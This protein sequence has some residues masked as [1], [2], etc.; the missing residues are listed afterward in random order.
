MN[1]NITYIIFLILFS[2]RIFIS[3]S[4]KESSDY[5]KDFAISLQ[6]VILNKYRDYNET[7]FDSNDFKKCNESLSFNISNSVNGIQLKKLMGIVGNSGKHFNDL[8]NEF[9]C[10]DISTKY[11]LNLS[12][13]VIRLIQE[14]GNQTLND[15]N[16]TKFLNMTRFLYG[17]CFPK[18]CF[19]LLNNTIFRNVTKSLMSL[20]DY[21]LYNS[22][23]DNKA[24]EEENS[25]TYNFFSVV[26]A[27]L[28]I[29]LFIKIIAWILVVITQKDKYKI[30]DLI[31]EENESDSNTEN[32]NGKSNGN[33]NE[34]NSENNES[35]NENKANENSKKTTET[36]FRYRLIY[37]DKSNEKE[38]EDSKIMKIISSLDISL[39][40]NYLYNKKNKYYD[41][42]NL[43][44]FFFLRAVSIL[45]MAYA[46][47]FYSMTKNPVPNIADDEKFYKSFSIVIL[48]LSTFFTVLW[49]GLEG[50]E[51]A[52]KLYSY[53]K[54]YILLSSTKSTNISI[55]VFLKFFLYTIPSIIVLFFCFFIMGYGI[56]YFDK[57]FYKLGNKSLNP[58]LY[59]F[60]DDVND[61][62]C[63]KEINYLFKPFTLNYY[64][65]FGYKKSGFHNRGFANCNKY[66]NILYNVFFLLYFITCCNLFIIK[67]KK[68]CI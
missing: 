11:N 28:L 43:E 62:K 18:E 49:I 1:K 37:Q 33:N 57:I 68:D 17:L 25:N 20:T 40:F 12:F 26:L 42:T 23:I 15:S 53:I 5:I 10:K 3:I 6:N 24:I 51:A 8:G 47:N 44:L 61:Y 13:F 32:N 52:F 64:N 21:T 4:D 50:F 9:N 54:K 35:N 27:I 41:S 60:I 7:I 56:E 14:I 36:I 39:S 38:K 19:D 67:N 34:N 55:K 46:H 2:Q 29:F 16:S 22:Y 66:V 59:Y 48:K 65:Y 63:N 45:F 31:V 58:M 30:S